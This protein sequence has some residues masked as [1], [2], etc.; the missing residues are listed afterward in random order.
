M[1]KGEDKLICMKLQSNDLVNNDNERIESIQYSVTLI[2]HQFFD[3]A[4]I[5]VVAKFMLY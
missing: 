1:H 2:Q 5:D 3:Y 4:E